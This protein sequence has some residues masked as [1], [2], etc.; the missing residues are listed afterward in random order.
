M[1][2]LFHVAMSGVVLAFLLSFSRANA[3]TPAIK[4]GM[5]V[6]S[7]MQEGELDVAKQRD[8]FLP[9]G[10]VPK[11]VKII[12]KL[13]SGKLSSAVSPT[14]EQARVLLWDEA[15]RKVDIR[16]ISL[17]HDKNSGTPKYLAMVAGKLVEIGDAVSA[18][19]EGQIYRW[20]VVGISEEGVSLQKLDVRGE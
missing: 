6:P 19:Y 13:E 5:I 15:R 17:I 7:D 1:R 16:G 10:Y 8:P 11:K 2:L 18:K 9:V 20:R 14:P 3:Q 12:K 4:G